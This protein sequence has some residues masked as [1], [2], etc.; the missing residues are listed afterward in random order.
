D[1]GIDAGVAVNVS[2]MQ[3]EQ[4]RFVD[5][6]IESMRL[7][8]LPPTKLELEITESMAVS[9]PTRVSSVME[10]LRA[11]GVSLAI[12][13]F[14]TGHS[15]LSMLSQLPFSTFKID[16]QFVSALDRGGQ[17]P[18]IIEMILAMAET[19]GLSTVAE[20]VETPMQADFLLRRGCTL[21]QGYLYSPAL[22]AEEVVGFATRWNSGES[23]DRKRAVGQI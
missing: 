3:F 7:T 5:K 19:L 21:A 22:P 17:A 6:I 15:N 12:D 14:G 13:D 10:P 20:G 11:M 16:R 2:P 1:A 18:A 9:D 23:Q 4:K 8:G